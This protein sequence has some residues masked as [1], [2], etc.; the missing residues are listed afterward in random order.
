M[1]ELLYEKIMKGDWI[2][3]GPNG[4]AIV[5]NES[6]LDSMDN[7]EVIKINNVADYYWKSKQ[8]YWSYETDFPNVAPPF[9][10][11]F[12]EFTIPQEICTHD[13]GFTDS[14]ITKGMKYGSFFT[15]K[16]IEDDE[17]IKWFYNVLHFAAGTNVFLYPA[18]SV[19]AVSS[20]GN[21][22]EYDYKFDG[23]S[24][25]KTFVATMIGEQGK[26]L[27][28]I[29]FGDLT[30]AISQVFLFPEL[31]AI[32]FMHCKN[33]NVIENKPSRIPGIRNRHKPK[34]TYKTL[35]IEP[36]K[37][38]LQ[39]EGDIENNGLKKAL[40]ICRGHFKDFREKG[41][42][43]RFHD[44]YWWDSQVRGKIENGMVIK[45]YDV[46]TPRGDA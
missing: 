29:F 23:K 20:E 17:N 16:K 27:N 41:L 13:R 35:E 26:S 24:I 39:T 7:C 34:I 25:E 42:F 22:I 30:S 19:M 11:F 28:D 8:T 4:D 38:V 2:N 40:H 10:K 21:I 31:L 18:A 14:L 44:I 43:G 1:S 15:S 5:D 45:N 36:M 37:K 32:S 12:M 9:N 33:V 3:R 46:K 6:L